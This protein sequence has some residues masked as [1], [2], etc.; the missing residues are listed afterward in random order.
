MS[1]KQNI[2]TTTQHPNSVQQIHA[3]E[4]RRGAAS[5]YAQDEMTSRMKPNFVSDLRNVEVLEGKPAHFEAKLAPVN[6]PNIKVEWFFNGRPLQ[7]G[8]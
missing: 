7:M 3:L 1:G 2:L 4:H 6:D 5:D 8:K